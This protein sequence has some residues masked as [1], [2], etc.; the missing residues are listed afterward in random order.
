MASPCAEYG[1][2][3][4]AFHWLS[5]LLTFIHSQ[6]FTLPALVNPPQIITKPEKDTW[7]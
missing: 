2:V 5:P 7:Q 1:N 4:A 6:V 3:G